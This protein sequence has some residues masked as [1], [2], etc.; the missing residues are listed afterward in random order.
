MRHTDDR[1]DVASVGAQ[2]VRLALR[3][4]LLAAIPLVIMCAIGVVLFR[5]G[6]TSDGR[7]TIAVGVI[8]AATCGASV[9]YQVDHWSL[10]RQ[11]GIHFA[12]M[13]I[14]VLPALL[15]SGWFPTH[16]PN[17]LIATV[18]LFLSVGLVLWT[19]IFLVLRLREHLTRD[20][21]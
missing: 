14:T 4:A 11:S 9:L 5:Q 16:T 19:S 15:L 21:S 1:P 7:S 17:G 13:V 18:L 20:R 10:M 8:I 12:V 6:Q 2:R 3:G